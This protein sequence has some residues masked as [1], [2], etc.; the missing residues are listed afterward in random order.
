VRGSIVV[1]LIAI[2]IPARADVK[3]HRATFVNPGVLFGWSWFTG[4][5]P[6]SFDIGGEVT[7]VQFTGRKI[8]HMHGEFDALLEPA[9]GVVAQI[10]GQGVGEN[11]RGPKTWHRRMM[12]G[13]EA[14]LFGYGVEL[15]V[16]HLTD[17]G[18]LRG[19]VYVHTAVFFGM[20][21]SSCAFVVDIPTGPREERANGGYGWM[22]GLAVTLKLPVRAR[23][24][25]ALIVGE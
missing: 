22:V 24:N 18:G 15:G 1:A 20:G 23:P 25:P 21:I 9:V 19:G 2:A 14:S 12:I 6:S 7:L 13:A 4:P 11:G 3:L 10:E 8:G 17:A 16:A 5:E